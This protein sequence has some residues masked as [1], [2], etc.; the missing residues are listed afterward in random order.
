VNRY[1]G[2]SLKLIYFVVST[3]LVVLDEGTIA[4]LE[5]NNKIWV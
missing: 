4:S 2:L 5:V 1:S 3:C